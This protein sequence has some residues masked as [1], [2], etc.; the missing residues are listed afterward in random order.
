LTAG[1]E[2]PGAGSAPAPSAARLGLQA[3]RTAQ[4]DQ[5][6]GADPENAAR[7][8][9]LLCLL[10]GMLTFAFLPLDPPTARGWIGW[11]VAAAMAL[12]DVIVA[13]RLLRAD[14][15]PSFRRLLALSY[16]GLLQVAVLCWLAGGAGTAYESLLL[17]WAGAGMGV[18]PPRRALLF[19][20]ATAAVT[21]L[22]LVY[23]GWSASAAADIAAN[24]L[25]WSALGIAM[26]VLMVGV[27]AQ[28]VRLR[29]AELRE[30]GLARED[31]L[32][33]LAN[34]RAFDEALFAEMARSARAGSRLSVLLIDLDHFK[35]INDELG[36]VEGDRCL[37]A[38]GAAIAR[39]VRAGDRAFRW[40]GDEFVVL[41]PDTDLAASESVA[42]GI[43]A[44]VLDTCS[45]S[46]GRPLSL[47]VGGVEG[48]GSVSASELLELADLQLRARKRERL[49]LTADEGP[50]APAP[51]GRDSD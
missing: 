40:G 30:S 33:G 5:Y 25:L 23:D 6:A 44:E 43:C 8:V 13:R 27:R 21:S 45:D 3:L 35:A 12:L 24:L 51:R 37:A 47:T 22:P 42:A 20:L 34:R 28:R 1:A 32:T 16:A 26:M 18:H 10:I 48:D 15:P 49:G 17:L 50:P 11:P 19:L 39:R 7:L 31:S 38:T 36:H 41:L 46:R 14:P 4:A 2:H 9:A 29:A